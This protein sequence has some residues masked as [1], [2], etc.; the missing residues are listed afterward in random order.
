MGS[1]ARLAG[2][3]GMASFGI[4]DV[5]GASKKK[6]EESELYVAFVVGLRVG[7]CAER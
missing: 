4:E 7:Q 5:D 3:S 2:R 1:D 6:E